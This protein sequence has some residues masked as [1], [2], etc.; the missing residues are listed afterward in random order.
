[1]IY[2]NF[3]IFLYYNIHQNEKR[4]NYVIKVCLVYPECYEVARFGIIRKEFSPFGIMYLASSLGWPV[5]N[6]QIIPTAVNN[7]FFD[8]SE[9]DLVSLHQF[10][11]L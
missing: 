11:I 1:M 9:F 5:V 7:N 10:F 3:S 6:V 8:F 2:S 4:G